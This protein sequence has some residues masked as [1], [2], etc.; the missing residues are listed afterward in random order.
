MTNTGEPVARLEINVVATSD[1]MGEE[2][3]RK[4][5]EQCAPSGSEA[6]VRG[7]S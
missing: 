2:R 5:T 1:P 3:G 4:A 7:L 6:G